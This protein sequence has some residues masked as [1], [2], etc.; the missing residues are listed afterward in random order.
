ME[1]I[2][3]TGGTG[4]I[5][6]HLL[7]ALTAQGYAVRALTR[8]DPPARSLPGLEWVPG[9]LEDLAS[10]RAALDSCNGVI[11]LAGLVQARTPAEF[12]RVNADGTARLVEAVVQTGRPMRLVY[13]SSLAAVGPAR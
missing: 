2:C 12:F 11:H 6:R 8:R 10:L 4:F 3:V 9:R 1:R 7:E 5:G 13:V